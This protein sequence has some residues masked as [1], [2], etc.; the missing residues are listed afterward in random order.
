MAVLPWETFLD[1]ERSDECIDSTMINILFNKEIKHFCNTFCMM[2][3]A[4]SGG[5]GGGVGGGGGD[6]GGGGGGGRFKD[7]EDD[8]DVFSGLETSR[9][10]PKFILFVLPTIYYRTFSVTLD[11]NANKAKFESRLCFIDCLCGFSIRVKQENVGS[12]TAELHPNTSTETII[13][14]RFVHFSE[15]YGSAEH[16][17]RNAG[18]EYT[19]TARR[20]IPT[21]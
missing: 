13:L 8:V 15:P 17:S 4:I 11:S 3:L 16:S 5:G 7:A 6:V 12:R 18:L 2:K 9:P 19:R 20:W 21:K 14:N 10:A 1:S